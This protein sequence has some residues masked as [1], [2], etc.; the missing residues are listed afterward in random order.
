M[1]VRFALSP[2]EAAHILVQSAAPGPYGFTPE[3]MWASAAAIL[4][5]AGAVIG[6]LALV[7]SARRIGNGGRRGAVVALAAGLIAAVNGALTLAVADGGPGTGNGVVGAAGAVVLGLIAIIL[8][9]TA[10]AR[11][12]RVTAREMAKV[13]R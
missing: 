7:R 1:S 4:A 3:R 2:A 6:V 9:G 13:A 5:L 10:L 12:R 11:A 8:G